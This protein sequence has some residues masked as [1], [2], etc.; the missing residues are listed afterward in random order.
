LENI[1][2]EFADKEQ[3]ESDADKLMNKL[4]SMLH[5]HTK[6]TSVRTDLSICWRIVEYWILNIGKDLILRIP[7]GKKPCHKTLVEVILKIIFFS[8]SETVYQRLEKY[9]KKVVL[10]Q[11]NLE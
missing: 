8:N 11:N 5:S 2:R 10:P 9:Q 1:L 3:L 6:D 7:T 4:H